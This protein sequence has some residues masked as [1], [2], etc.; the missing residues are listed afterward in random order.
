M[1]FKFLNPTQ[2]RSVV[3]AISTVH[4][5]L[6]EGVYFY[7]VPFPLLFRLHF[8]K[9]VHRH[10]DT[11]RWSLYCCCGF[12]YRKALRT[13]PWQI[14][15]YNVFILLQALKSECSERYVKNK[16]QTST[17]R[18]YPASYQMSVF[19]TVPMSGKYYMSAEDPSVTFSTISMF[20]G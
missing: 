18:L 6:R 13:F 11:H 9:S 12:M 7:G 17:L 15:L 4:Y 10:E 8:M 16:L 14:F 3:N 2:T 20:F 19:Q 5:D 1:P